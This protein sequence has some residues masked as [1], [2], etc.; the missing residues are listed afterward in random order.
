MATNAVIIFVYTF[1]SYI[2]F[3]AVFPNNHLEMHVTVEAFT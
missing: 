3:T 2:K 1:I